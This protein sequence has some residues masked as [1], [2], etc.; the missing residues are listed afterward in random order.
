MDQETKDFLGSLEQENGGLII[1]KTYAVLIG[2]SNGKYLNLGGLL[3]IINKT[4]YFEDFEK[5]SGLFGM[6]TAKKK[7]VYNKYKTSI[8]INSIDNIFSVKINA[9]KALASG[10]LSEKK[11]MPVTG[12][13]KKLFQT[14]VYLSCTEEPGWLLEVIDD[15]AFIK[16]MK[17]QK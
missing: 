6:I 9:A 12:F 17:E 4:L 10:K 1:F 8:D 11:I 3:F 16:I 14:A 7:K 5:Q 15:K 2:F 13:Q